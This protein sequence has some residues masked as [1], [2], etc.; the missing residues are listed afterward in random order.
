MNYAV[1]ILTNWKHF[2]KGVTYQCED[3]DHTACSAGKLREHRVRKHGVES[4]WKCDICGHREMSIFFI[5]V[6]KAK[7]KLKDLVSCNVSIFH[8]LNESSFVVLQR[9]KELYVNKFL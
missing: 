8:L 4:K 9:K 5:K 2:E 3:C 1:I 7:L 6:L